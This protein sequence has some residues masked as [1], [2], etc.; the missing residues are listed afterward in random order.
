M[1]GLK[2]S[3]GLTGV[4]ALL[5][6]IALSTRGWWRAE[7]GLSI[8]GKV[9]AVRVAAG[10]FDVEIDTA[11]P[12]AA[13]VGAQLNYNVHSCGSLTNDSDVDVCDALS[14]WVQSNTHSLYSFLFAFFFP[15]FIY[16]VCSIKH[17]LTLYFLH[18]SIPL[19]CHALS[20]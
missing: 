2:R 12:K 4:A 18:S 19:H 16:Q 5:C 15:S 20:R 7:Y 6:L 14:R 17:P 9:Y 10:L 13:L 8:S 3:V 11:L 1:A